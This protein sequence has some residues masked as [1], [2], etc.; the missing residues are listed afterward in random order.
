M[1]LSPTGLRK[2]SQRYADHL[3]C[4][5]ITV[6]DVDG[7]SDEKVFIHMKLGLLK[8]FGKFSTAANRQP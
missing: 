3:D 7:V 6:T 1:G 5:D 4:L 2:L 8:S